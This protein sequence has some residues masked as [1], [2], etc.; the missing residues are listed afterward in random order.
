MNCIRYWLKLVQMQ[1][2][3]LPRKAYTSLY[4]LD[5][6]GHTN[7][8]WVSKV[9]NCLCVNGFRNVWMQQGVG[10][11]KSFLKILK[12]RL[13][14][15]R[16]QNVNGHLNGSE[17]FEF[18]NMFCEKDFAIPVYLYLDVNRQ[19]KYMM[20]KFRF[21]VSNLNVHYFRYRN[22]NPNRMLCQYCKTEIESELHFILVCPLYEEIRNQFIPLK[23]YR[24]PNLFKLN[25]LLASKSRNI[26][27][28]LCCY[29]Y[30]AFK[31]RGI[32]CE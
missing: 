14:D 1:N 26:V 6:R 18:Y 11:V 31:I 13:I 30:N 25:L 10:D 17:R 27:E 20:T 9:R 23:Y 7:Y 19:L 21:G 2:H 15:V 32:V 5:E 16:W 28:N 8:N 12:Q 4:T 3:R 29:I 22:V 24:S